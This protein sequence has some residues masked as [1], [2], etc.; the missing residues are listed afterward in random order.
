[1]HHLP[2]PIA[3]HM[4]TE[5]GKKTKN[6]ADLLK[7]NNLASIVHEDAKM[8][9]PLPDQFLHFSKRAKASPTCPHDSSNCEESLLPKLTLGE[10]SPKTDV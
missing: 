4:E 3:H 1:M 2:K 9:R 7:K 10:P 5:A 6:L 8:Q